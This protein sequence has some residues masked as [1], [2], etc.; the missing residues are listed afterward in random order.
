MVL[1]RLR[2]RSSPFPSKKLKSFDLQRFADDAT[3]FKLFFSE[4]DLAAFPADV[5][6]RIR[7]DCATQSAAVDHRDFIRHIERFE[8]RCVLD[9]TDADAFIDRKSV[10]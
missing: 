8:A 5:A 9:Q 6:E 4:V 3:A 2:E 7:S 10:V 1:G